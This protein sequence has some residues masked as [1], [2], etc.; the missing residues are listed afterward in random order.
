MGRERVFDDRALSVCVFMCGYSK[1]VLN[2]TVVSQNN[3]FLRNRTG[4][5]RVMGDSEWLDQRLWKIP[6]KNKYYYVRFYNVS[7]ILCDF[8][9][10]FQC[11][12]AF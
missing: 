11:C 12:T 1:Q 10:I 3:I 7:I 8:F 4:E 6:A 9:R 2:R 5:A